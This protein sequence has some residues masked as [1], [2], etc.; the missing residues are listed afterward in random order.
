MWLK[1]KEYGYKK[2]DHI[3]ARNKIQSSLFSQLE[4]KIIS[5]KSSKT[6]T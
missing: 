5:H 1:R 6:V 4:C 3:E 2:N